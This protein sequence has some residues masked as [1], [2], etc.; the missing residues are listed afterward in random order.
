MSHEKPTGEQPGGKL[1]GLR[2][3]HLR[4]SALIGVLVLLLGFA[5]AIQVR[6]NSS[7]DAL[8]NASETDLISILDDQDSR[9]DRLRQQIAAL[10][11]TEQQLQASG[12]RDTVAL[13]QA[14]QQAQ[15][16]GVLLGTLPA[17]GPGISM[18][19]TDPKH[20]L[21]AA[22]LLDV[23]EELRGAGAEA[24][25]FGPIRVSTS[26]AFTDSTAG[27]QLDGQVVAPPYTVL[28]IGDGQT[29]QTAMEIPG[30][31]AATAR[32]AGGNADVQTQP[33]VDIGV[34]RS[35][36]NPRY[37]KPAGR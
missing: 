29:L 17:T 14:Q 34:V 22:D 12:S 15:A 8:S 19:I 5:I 9:A 20:A 21:K 32:A 7:G 4:A 2:G 33:T 10:Q 23:V 36:P 26:S 30:G 28:A 11:T 31:V 37:A 3:R 16:L 35:V 6:T 13:Q 18:T 27:V 1:A 24:I 25:Q